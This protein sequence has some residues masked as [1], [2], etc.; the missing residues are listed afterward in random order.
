MSAITIDLKDN[1]KDNIIKEIKLKI[2]AG[3]TDNQ[4][5]KDLN[6][7]FNSNYSLDLHRIRLNIIELLIEHGAH[8]EEWTNLAKRLLLL[9][10]PSCIYKVN[11]PVNLA[12][13]EE[14]DNHLIPDLVNIIK[15]YSKLP[16]YIFI[17]NKVIAV[18][19]YYKDKSIIKYIFSIPQAELHYFYQYINSVEK[20]WFVVAE[21]KLWNRVI[22]HPLE[23]I[24]PIQNQI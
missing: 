17:G 1:L 18:D 21:S 10:I 5:E 20:Q 7:L 24:T 6:P 8:E 2:A 9:L 14:L 22:T 16:S 11:D 13:F 19:K 4:L 3:Y 12:A 23:E 15:E